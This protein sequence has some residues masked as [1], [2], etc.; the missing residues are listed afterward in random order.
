MANLT[1]VARHGCEGNTR[2]GKDGSRIH[3][4][5]FYVSGESAAVADSTWF[6]AEVAGRVPPSSGEAIVGRRCP[7]DVVLCVRISSR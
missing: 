5:R 7:D 6:V 1:P 2:A 4:R 3:K